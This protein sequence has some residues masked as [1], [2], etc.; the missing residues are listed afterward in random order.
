M[1]D[2]YCERS[3]PGLWAEPVNTLTNLVFLAAAYATRRLVQNQPSEFSGWGLV[4]SRKHMF[5]V[6]LL[7]VLMITIGIGSAL[8]HTF[9]TTW[10]RILDI[11]PI[12]LF[13]VFYLLF[14]SRT[15]I[16]MGKLSTAAALGGFFL[17]ALLG[18]QFPSI[19]NGSLIYAPAFLLLNGLGTYHFVTNKK[20]RFT[21]WAASGVFLFSVFFRSIDMAVCP[22]FS[23]GTHFLWHILNG[24]VLYLAM[25]GLL[26]NWQ[27]V[28]VFHPE[29]PS[30]L[31]TVLDLAAIALFFIAG[32]GVLVSEV[33]VFLFLFQSKFMNM[34]FSSIGV[35]GS[36][37]VLS[38]AGMRK[39]FDMKT[40]PFLDSAVE[41]IA[42][43]LFFF[44][45]IGILAN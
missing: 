14:Y 35:I 19:L 8:F 13:Q 40:P 17:G 18:R 9:A 24:T 21:L 36:I 45:G 41:L 32:V 26:L 39:L 44:G 22:F 29:S 3:G 33:L 2:L 11:V 23:L 6:A 10:A 30:F 5:S 34:I 38:I 16:L 43:V 7:V 25:R 31:G 20:G 28:S 27:R 1:I 42:A 4:Y 12:L 37:V 15:V